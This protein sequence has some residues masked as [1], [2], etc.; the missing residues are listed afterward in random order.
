M[1][2]NMRRNVSEKRC[3]RK[4]DVGETVT[5]KEILKKRINKRGPMQMCA[6][7][8]SSDTAWSRQVKE[9]SILSVHVCSICHSRLGLWLS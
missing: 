1:R 6:V 2:R 4:R 7:S 9:F 5:E 8:M 3:W